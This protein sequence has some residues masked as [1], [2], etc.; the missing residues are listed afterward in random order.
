MFRKELETANPAPKTVEDWFQKLASNLLP[1]ND[2]AISITPK[3]SNS[4]KA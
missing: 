1:D 4:E 2:S 3:D